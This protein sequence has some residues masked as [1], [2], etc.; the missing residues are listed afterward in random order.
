MPQVTQPG[1][2]RAGMGTRSTKSRSSCFYILL[3]P[4]PPSGPGTPH[5]PLSPP[6]S[7]LSLGLCSV[8]LSL[9]GLL[10]AMSLSPF[11]YFCLFISPSLSSLSF[12]VS[13]S[14]LWSLCAQLG[15]RRGADTL[16]R[17]AGLGWPGPPA[18]SEAL[19]QCFPGRSKERMGAQQQRPPLTPAHSPAAGGGGEADSSP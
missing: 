9:L 11:S 18:P 17:M 14:S 6:L 5:S 1:E 13:P 4:C 2:G 7:V 10:F 12:L 19:S 15:A 16:P 8:F 3:P